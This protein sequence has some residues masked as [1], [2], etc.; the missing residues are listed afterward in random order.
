MKGIERY[1]ESSEQGQQDSVKR[2]AGRL[3]QKKPI[4]TILARMASRVMGASQPACLPAAQE[5]LPCD[6]ALLPE[7]LPATLGTSDDN[8]RKL[9]LCPHPSFYYQQTAILIMKRK[10]TGKVNYAV[11]VLVGWLVVLVGWLVG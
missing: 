11:G 5:L 1:Q 3:H 6:R 2:G 9:N 7:E 10:N 8:Q 4:L